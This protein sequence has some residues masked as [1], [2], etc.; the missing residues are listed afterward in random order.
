MLT[1][2]FSFFS[3]V[4]SHPKNHNNLIYLPTLSE[5][6]TQIFGFLSLREVFTIFVGIYLLES[7][8][9]RVNVHFSRIIEMPAATLLNF[10][11]KCLIIIYA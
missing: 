5:R 8:L 1:L 9:N 10:G 4:E 3:M 11:E 2:R 6:Q 7:Y